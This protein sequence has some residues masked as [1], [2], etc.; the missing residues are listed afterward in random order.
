MQI[1]FISLLLHITNLCIY[2]STALR[3]TL[4]AFQFLHLL[5]S[6]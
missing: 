6:Q 2:G 5:H 1:N 3:W 4:V